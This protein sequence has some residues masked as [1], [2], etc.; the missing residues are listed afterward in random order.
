MVARS[1]V[2]LPTVG[3]RR[4]RYQ[5]SKSV[6][7]LA[8]VINAFIATGTPIQTSTTRICLSVCCRTHS[9]LN[10]LAVQIR[11]TGGGAAERRRE[12]PWEEARGRVHYRAS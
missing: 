10:C 7:A 2:I 1:A 6:Y 11:G 9:D 3:C 8:A 12:G 4:G 5:G